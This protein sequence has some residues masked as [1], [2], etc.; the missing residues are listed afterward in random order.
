MKIALTSLVILLSFNL[1]F[2]Q[3][4]GNLINNNNGTSGNARPNQLFAKKADYS[5]IK[6][7]GIPYENMEFQPGLIYINGKPDTKARIRYN[8]YNDVL[9]VNEGGETYNLLRRDYIWAEVNGKKYGILDYLENGNKKSG[10]LVPISE[11]EISLYFKP[12][13]KLTEGREPKSGFEQYIPPKFVNDHRFYI[14]KK[15]GVI[16]ETR[17]SNRML[18]DLFKDDYKKVKDFIKDNDLDIKEAE[19]LA[20][21]FDYYKQM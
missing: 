19:D 5:D 7:E 15:D 10:Y 1:G 16:E 12:A 6:A 21:V 3:E 4:G 8:A 13:K 2:T 20:K 18:K 11:G 14:K 9:E 17:I